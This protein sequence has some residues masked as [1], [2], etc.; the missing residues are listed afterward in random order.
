MGSM[1]EKLEEMTTGKKGK[2]KGENSGDAPGNSTKNAT[3]NE[4]S[5][6]FKGGGNHNKTQRKLPKKGGINS[7]SLPQEYRKLIES[8]NKQ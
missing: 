2:G 5:E 4:K 7:N 6:N 1:L 3:S 8:Y